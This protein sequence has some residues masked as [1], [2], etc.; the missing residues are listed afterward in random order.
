MYIQYMCSCTVKPVA[1]G[2]ILAALRYGV[3]VH[4]Q[5]HMVISTF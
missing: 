2:V 4:D 3:S 1:V 5:A